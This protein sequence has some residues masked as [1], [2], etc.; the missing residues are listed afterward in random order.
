MAL[1]AL[2][3]EPARV[4][5]VLRVAGA[6][7]HG[8]FDDVLRLEMALGATDLRM[9]PRQREERSCRMVEVPE[10]PAVRGMALRARF[11]E[12]AVV[13]ILS[14]VAGIAVPGGLLE[15]LCHMA[16][17]AGRGHM[18]TK[19]RVS[20]QIMVERH[21]APFRVGVALLT[22]RVH[23]RPMRAGGSMAADAIRASFLFLQGRRVAGMAIQPG[24][25][26]CQ[27]EFR[28]VISSDPPEIVAVTL[29]AGGAE[30]AFVPIICLVAAVAVFRH[31]CMEIATA[32]AVRAANVSV[33]S[34]KG[35]A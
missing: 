34:E 27:L 20:G 16:L 8:R 31:G 25:G 30:T 29:T 32:M 24:V 9:S 28:M 1:L 6:A 22:S 5:V 23:G 4:H 13:D 15:V 33:P 2:L 10:F 3:P 17:T 35:E 14:R 7:N 26:S 21:I 19:K 11:G 18:Q 12:R